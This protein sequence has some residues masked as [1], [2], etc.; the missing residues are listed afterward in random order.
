MSNIDVTR[1]QEAMGLVR[2]HKH[3]IREGAV[4]T[5]DPK[6]KILLTHMDC[7][8]FAMLELGDTVLDLYTSLRRLRV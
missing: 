5:D 4:D 3:L 7:L 1:L 6:I 8:S 2:Q